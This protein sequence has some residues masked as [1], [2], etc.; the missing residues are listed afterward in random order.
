[1][2]STGQRG[3]DDCRREATA[4]ESSNIIIRFI[5]MTIQIILYEVQSA[6][7]QTFSSMHKWFLTA[8]TFHQPA[9]H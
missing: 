7:P 8:S 4:N 3:V 6:M 9:S 1:M 5:H 2:R